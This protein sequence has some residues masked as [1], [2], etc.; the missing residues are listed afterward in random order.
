ME[1]ARLTL[2]VDCPALSEPV[3]VDRDMWE[4]IVLN[5]LSNA[6]KFTFEGGISV[7]VREEMD[8][9]HFAVLQVRDTGTGIPHDQ[10]S[11]IFERFHR[12]QGAR[13]RT[14]EGTGIG[15]ALV[16]QLVQLHGG[17]IDAT[18]EL[19]KGSVFTVRVPFGTSHLAQDHVRR[20]RLLTSTATRADVFV[21]EA[22]RWLLPTHPGDDATGETEPP[23]IGTSRETSAREAPGARGRPRVLVVD[24]NADMRGYL[25]RLLSQHYKVESVSNG[26]IAMEHVTADPP[27][28]VLT[29]VMMPEVDGFGLLNELR[30]RPATKTLPV[31]L[32][33]ARAGEES[34]IEGLERGADDY[35]I[36]PFSAKE[37][38]ARVAAHLEIARIRREAELTLHYQN[39]QFETLL[40]QAPLGV[41]LVDADL[42]I[43]QANPVAEPVF[44]DIP[45]LIGRDLDEVVHVLWEKPYADEIMNCFRHTLETGEPYVAPERIERRSDRGVTE[46]YEWRIDRIVLA[47]GRCGVVCYCRDVSVQ[48]L[49]REA[50]QRSEERLREFAAQLEQLVAERTQELVQ[51]QARLRALATELN[52]TEQRERKRLAAELHDHL[53]QMLVLGKLKL[54]QGMR[55][56]QIVPRALAFM[57]QTDDVLAEALEYTRTLVAELSPPVLHEH[58]LA[59]GL[60]WL[61]N[62]M[63]RHDMKVTVRVPETE[64][65]LP[66]DQAVL[67]FQS[68]RE[69][70]INASK[71][72]RSPEAN[73]VLQR[74]DGRLRIE[75]TDNGVGFDAAAPPAEVLQGAASSKFGLF[76]IRERMKA[77]GGTFEIGSIPGK[78]TTATLSLLV[79]DPGSRFDVRTAT[80]ASAARPQALRS[81]VSASSSQQPGEFGPG[82]EHP[83]RSENHRIRVLLV[84]DHAMVR[85]G[86]RSV[87]ESYDDVEVV[88]EAA[89]GED[90]VALVE[91]LRPTM[92]VMDI[93]MPGLNG[94]EATA[95]ITRTYP[96]IHVIGLSVNA[97]GNNVQA[98]L[99]AGAVLLLTKEAAVNEL[100]RRM[101]EV[102]LPHVGNASAPH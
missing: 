89:N 70:L 56:P 26:R 34:R 55:M 37:L 77:L 62:H 18:S 101:R 33:S 81:Q 87:L 12:V 91:R 61:A 19:V 4:K 84:D 45:N 52:L 97:S 20:E 11:Q 5:L 58:G 27:D 24:D 102:L 30:R 94:I 72:A 6:F 2:H 44:G 50:L 7:T 57:K 64:V 32:L 3:Y 8:P 86:L 90:A 67:L 17:T 46:S 95:Y 21:E 71:H 85:E 43:V 40:N 38:L 75:V 63:K 1:Q 93:N 22:L 74:G 16:K 60:A 59:A 54:G 48:I 49:A 14:I 35:L 31:I 25:G 9:S 68:V 28:L 80:I 76:S 73:V 96:E 39:N 69:L 13:G 88:G 10:L 79:S 65:A 23:A 82:H 92:V 42:R 51:S 15:L 53:Q 98:M 36:K 100:Y 66:E 29:D 99:K 78:G 47:D 41:Y 83:I